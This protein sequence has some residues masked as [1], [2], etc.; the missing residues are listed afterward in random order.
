MRGP[1]VNRRA[2]GFISL[3]VT[4]YEGHVGTK[5]ACQCQ[6]QP[7]SHVYSDI[8]KRYVAHVEKHLFMLSDELCN[9]ADKREEQQ[10]SS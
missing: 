10:S 7:T 5:F 1:N 4:L 2:G 9:P 6:R 3:F 8:E